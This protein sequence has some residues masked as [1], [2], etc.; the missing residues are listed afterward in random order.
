MESIGDLIKLDYYTEHKTRLKY[1]RLQIEVEVNQ[2]F[3]DSIWFI[4]EKGIETE[5]E[6]VYEWK[7]TTCGNCNKMG[8]V[9]NECKSKGKQKKVWQPKKVQTRIPVAQR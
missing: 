6:V 7:P 8:H 4:N 3:P 9:D 2:K 1:A 5:Q